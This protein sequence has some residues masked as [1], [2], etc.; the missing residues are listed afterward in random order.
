MAINFAG[1]ISR[2]GPGTR[3]TYRKTSMEPYE[4]INS[5]EASLRVIIYEILA[6]GW[7]EGTTID[8]ER[9]EEKRK[10]E[11]ASRKGSIVDQSL[12]VYTEFYQLKEIVLKKWEKFK[13]IFG[14][15]KRFESYY[16][17]AEHLRNGVMHSRELLPFERDL[18]SGIS[19]EIRNLVAIYRSSM[20]PDSKYYPTVETITDSFGNDWHLEGTKTI[21]TRAQV[22]TTVEFVCRA[23]DPAARLL[24]WKLLINGQEISEATGNNVTLAWPVIESHVGENTFI[25]IKMYSNGKYHRFL[26]WDG[27]F[28]ARY[29]VDPPNGYVA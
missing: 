6:D 25:Y 13:P 27:N 18:L 15:K 22:G 3:S 11:A 19:G 4:A 1:K 12:L 5:I 28:V 8:L 20:G 21:S 9:L 10:S 7:S 23:W 2:H 17:R 16:D 29:A 14:D 26:Q 24:T